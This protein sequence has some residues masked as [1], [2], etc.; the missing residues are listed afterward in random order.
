MRAQVSSE[1]LGE[2]M[3][4]DHPAIRL[5]IRCLCIAGGTYG[6]WFA[7][8]ERMSMA[9]IR[10]RI[11]C[12]TCGAILLVHVALSMTLDQL[13]PD[14]AVAVTYL[15]RL[16]VLKAMAG[17]AFIGGVIVMGIL[18]CPPL[19]ARSRGLRGPKTTP[20]PSIHPPL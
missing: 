14:P 13:T 1:E 8:G 16:Y 7:F 19:D 18:N 20:D 12:I 4:H 15:R 9:S 2:S 5:A 10:E 11:A 3:I 17:G 6:I